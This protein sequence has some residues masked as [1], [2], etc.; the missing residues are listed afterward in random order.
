MAEALRRFAAAYVPPPSPS[1]SP[2]SPPPAVRFHQDGASFA[3]GAVRFGLDYNGTPLSATLSQPATDGGGGGRGGGGGGG[4]L[5]EVAP[6]VAPHAGG[7]RAEASDG[8]PTEAT[9]GAAAHFLT[10]FFNT[11]TVDLDGC[12]LRFRALRLQPAGAAGAAGGAAAAG[13]GELELHLELGV[14]VRRFPS[15]FVNF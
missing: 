4:A 8:A 10:R 15:P 1:P 6:P 9:L 12:E 2:P 7:A 3:P 14:C 11:L 13:R 5:V